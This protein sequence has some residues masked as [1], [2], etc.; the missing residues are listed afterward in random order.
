MNDPRFRLA[1]AL[2]L[3]VAA[4]ASIYGAFL[5]A[6]WWAVFSQRTRSLPAPKKVV[7]AF[8]SIAG[9]GALIWLAGGDGLS[10]LVRFSAIL[11]IAAWVHAEHR[12]GEFLSVSV[13]LLGDRVGFDLGL[14]AEMA[15]GTLAA[16]EDDLGHIR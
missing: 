15:M 5:A 3:S 7:V 4:F 8:A 10:Y 11:L 12:S 14:V 1:S 6:C 2:L 16:L 9:V 13:W